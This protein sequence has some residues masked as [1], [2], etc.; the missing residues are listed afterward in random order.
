M[1][2]IVVVATVLVRWVR[3]S[4]AEV[5]TE[6]ERAVLA[7]QLMAADREVLDRHADDPAPR[8]SAERLAAR[9]GRPTPRKRGAGPGS[10]SR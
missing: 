4:R 6:A 2:S 1:G 8:P 10:A 7:D 9:D 3:P 5:P